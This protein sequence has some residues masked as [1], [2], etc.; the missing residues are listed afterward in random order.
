MT[1]DEAA[2]WMLHEYERDG[3]LYQEAAACH[4]FQLSN[5]NLAYFDK[6]S[7]LCIGKTVLAI[8]NGLTPDAVYERSDKFWRRRLVTDQVG[9]Q[10]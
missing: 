5:D 10:Q 3:F 8:F 2:R 4:L 6:N 9:R 1:E 7:N